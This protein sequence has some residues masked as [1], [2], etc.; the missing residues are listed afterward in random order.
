MLCRKCYC[1]LFPQYGD[2]E[3]ICAACQENARAPL[4]PAI[5]SE[6]GQAWEPIR[7]RIGSTG[8]GGGE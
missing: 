4:P 3:D 7:G 2:G 8:Y 1:L 6:P 5:E